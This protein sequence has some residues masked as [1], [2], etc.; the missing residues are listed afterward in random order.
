[1]AGV[2]PRAFGMSHGTEDAIFPME[3]VRQVTR[4][5]RGAFAPGK[6]LA[7]TFRGPHCFPG[8][9][10]RRAYAFLRRHLGA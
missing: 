5:A 9:V 4:R 2:A 7:V 8:A 10:K 6:F 3:G 1:V